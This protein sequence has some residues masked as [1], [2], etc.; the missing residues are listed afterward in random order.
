MLR[1]TIPVL[2]LLSATCLPLQPVLASPPDGAAALETV[3]AHAAD[4]GAATAHAGRVEAVR[5]ATVAAQ[6]A[7][8]ITALHVKAGDR[9]VAGQE[10]VHIDSRVAGKT[11]VASAAQTD[12]AVAMLA[13]ARSEFERQ[14]RLF[15]K[16]YISQA[17]LERAE[18]QYKS[19]AA[20]A[21]A[22]QAAADAAGTQ[23]GL[24][25]LRAPFD[26]IVAEVPVETGDMAMPGS[27][28]LA[29]FAPDAL[30]V[31]ADV[32][33]GAL[34]ADAAAQDIELELPDGRMLSPTAV[35]VLPT[36]DAR[37]HTVRLRL[38]LPPAAG[39][40]APGSY[41]RVWLPGAVPRAAVL[42]PRQA[43]VRRAEMTGLYV[44]DAQQRP[45]LR[46]VRLGAEHGDLVEVLAGVDAGD[47]V[48]LDPQAAARLRR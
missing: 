10:L 11:A 47:A 38:A 12:A 3:S 26:A 24:F 34:P 7:G 48:V 13:A 17:A 37:S 41:A 1:Q 28:L 15:E 42:V 31:V 44:L 20:Q 5:S 8:T 2:M 27:P 23:A 22:Q 4:A 43:V 19:A 21:R 6:V 33:Q 25:V 18:A 16:Q 40:V 14:Q 30:R 29:L 45:L 46:Q 9:V 36:L 39:V 35:E 32:P